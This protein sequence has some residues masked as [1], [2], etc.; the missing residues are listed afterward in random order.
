MEERRPSIAIIGAGPVGLAAAAELVLRGERPLVLETGASAGAAVRHWGQVRLFSPWRYNLSPAGRDL[1]RRQGWAE[2]P[3]EELPTGLQLVERYLE[4]LSATPELRDLIRFDTRVLSIGRRGFDK[5]AGAGREEAPFELRVRSPTGVRSL[6]ARAVIDAS[7]TWQTPNPLG[8]GGLPAEGE[9]EAAGR[10]FYGIPDVLGRE[11]GRFAGRRIA[12]VGAGHSA[13]NALLDLTEL[14][15]EEPGTRV[16]WLIR[17]EDP[18]RSFGGGAADALPARGELGARI[19]A[20]VGS[21]TVEVVAGFRTTTIEVLG[22]EAILHSAG[23]AA[24]P[25][26]QVVVATGFRP[27]LRL[28]AELRLDLD[29]VVEAP[30][31]LAPLIDP[32]LHSCGTVRPHGSA[33]LE[34]PEAGFFLAGMKSYGRAPTFLMLTGYEQV[35]SIAC[36]LTGDAEGARRVDLRLPETGACSAAPAVPRPSGRSLTV[37]ASGLGG[38][39]G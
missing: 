35:R 11:R 3:A 5:L 13:L 26:D 9:T 8:A 16:T 18:A 12:V 21:G 10:L 33:E 34:Q 36:H 15:R 1:L 6:L 20:M 4:P 2:P 30:R 32:N 39:C 27:D 25:F 24:G 7:G 23:R 14:A 37:I 38:C 17:L 22:A 28:T 29:P 31:L 19:A